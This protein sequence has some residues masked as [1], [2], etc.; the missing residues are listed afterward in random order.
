MVTGQQAL[1]VKHDEVQEQGKKRGAGGE[2]KEPDL[3]PV[4]VAENLVGARSLLNPQRVFVSTN[5][6]SA[7]SMPDWLQTKLLAPTC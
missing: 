6:R 7:L 3:L 5:H 2:R 4:P 1:I